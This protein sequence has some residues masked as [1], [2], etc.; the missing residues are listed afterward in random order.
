[1]IDALKQPAKCASLA[2]ANRIEGFSDVLR[3]EARAEVVERTACKV[4]LKKDETYREVAQLLYSCFKTAIDNSSN[5]NV[6]DLLIVPPYAT[7]VDADYSPRFGDAT[8]DDIQYRYG[9]AHIILKRSGGVLD[10]NRK[11]YATIII[12]FEL[13]TDT[14]EQEIRFFSNLARMALDSFEKDVEKVSANAPYG[15]V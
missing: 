15:R 6:A 1:M 2:S 11:G 9:N 8:S 7:A 3:R 13:L 5:K 14:S 10:Q 4:D 12:H